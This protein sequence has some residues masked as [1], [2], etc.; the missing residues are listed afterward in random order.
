MWY[1]SLQ[2]VQR[3][4]CFLSSL[5]QHTLQSFQGVKGLRARSAQR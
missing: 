2:R 1:P 4:K 3:S 5:L